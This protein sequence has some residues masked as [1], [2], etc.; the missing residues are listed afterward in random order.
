MI[1]WK[2]RG[3][4]GGV[5]SSSEDVNPVIFEDSSRIEYAEG[6]YWVFSVMVNSEPDL[7]WTWM[8]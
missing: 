7:P 1:R 8:G 2:L 4:N 6:F 5:L 3:E